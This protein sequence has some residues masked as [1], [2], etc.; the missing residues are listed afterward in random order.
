MLGSAAAVLRPSPPERAAFA[1]HRPEDTTLHHV[2]REN[3][4]TLYAAL[5]EQG[6]RLPDFVRDELEGYLGCGLLTRGFALLRCDDC[7]ESQLVAFSCG[8]RG[9]CPSCLGRR[10]AETAANLVEHVLPAVPLRQWVLTLPF[11]LRSRLAYDGEL[12]G[13]IGRLLSDSLLG[14]YR[15][16]MALDGFAR[17]RSGVI[18]VVQRVAS[19]MKLAP[20]FHALSLDGVYAESVTGELSFHT[21]PRL[22]TDE[23]ADVLQ[24]VRI[25]VTRLLERRGLLDEHDGEQLTLRTDDALAD[26]EPALA[27]LAQTAVGAKPPAGPELRRRLAEVPLPGRP[28]LTVAGSLCVAE[29]GFSLH[30]ATRAGPHDDGARERLVRYV[31]RPP[32]ATERL[33]LL[34]DELVRLQLKK[35]FSDGTVAIDLDPLSLLWRLCAAVPPPRRHTVVYS[36][37]VSS[38]AKWRSQIVPAPDAAAA[39]APTAATPAP[40]PPDTTAPEKDATSRRRGRSRR[41]SRAELLVRS[42]GHDAALCPRCGGKLRLHA[43]V[44]DP[45]S[46][47]RILRHR[48]EPTEPP[49]IA[50]ARGPPIWKSKVLLRRTADAPAEW[51]DPQRDL[52]HT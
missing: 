24:T 11:A 50:P 13:R 47:R 17:G 22:R 26:A 32:L 19:D 12:L 21:L 3:L 36:G 29:Q 33:R 6:T 7:R 37:V 5:E 46:I 39:P 45:A 40:S 23:V 31:L 1:R 8:S 35:P 14:F 43:I 10:M 41:R 9:F 16:R 42:F 52:F 18:N 25:R 2:V 15:R 27:H 44:Q 28:G 30:A 20:H 49:P 38:H 34:P 51:S 4:Q 48:G